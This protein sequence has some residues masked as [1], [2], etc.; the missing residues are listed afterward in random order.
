MVANY[1]DNFN[2]TLNFSI[3]EFVPS[4]SDHC[5]LHIKII[6]NKAKP[7]D[8]FNT[9]NL[10]DREPGFIWNE[11]Y[12]EKFNANLVSHEI[13]N[14]L[15]SLLTSDELEPT[16]LAKEIKDTLLSIARNCKLKKN[17]SS[18]K[19]PSQPWFDKQCLSTKNNVLRLDNKL[20]RTPG[21]VEIRTELFTQKKNLKD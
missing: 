21:D 16:Q 1:F 13:K 11:R 20:K 3:G 10:H 8:N 15:V 9:F 6:L 17:K 7:K 19:N 18:G 4:L 14:K 2:N 12:K 5:P